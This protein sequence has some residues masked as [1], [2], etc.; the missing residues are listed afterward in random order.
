MYL[1]TVRGDTRNPSFSSS[2]LAV[3]SSPHT[4]FSSEICRIR[5]RSAAGI[6]GAQSLTCTS[7][8]AAS[9]PGASGSRFRAERQRYTTANRRVSKTSPDSRESQHRCGAA[10]IS[11]PYI[12]PAGAGGRGSPLPK[13][14]VVSMRAL[15]NRSGPRGLAIECGEALSRR[16]NA[17]AVMA[18]GIV[19][20]VDRIIADHSVYLPSSQSTW[21]AWHCSRSIPA[22]ATRK[23]AD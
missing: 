12:R 23:C 18:P 9:L 13:S 17:T 15:P 1:R 2:S 20:T 10:L 3:R 4:G 11:A 22:H 19:R 21:R 6:L 16:D 5:S 7:G 14:A 8:I